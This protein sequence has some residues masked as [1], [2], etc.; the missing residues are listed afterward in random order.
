MEH[1][2]M[3]LATMEHGRTRAVNRGLVEIT[4]DGYVDETP[5][6][7]FGMYILRHEPFPPTGSDELFNIFLAL[8]TEREGDPTT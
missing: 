7:D 1:G 5:I 2:Q 3:Y 4:D 8:V 6:E